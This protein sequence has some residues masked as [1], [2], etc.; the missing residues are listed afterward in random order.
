MVPSSDLIRLLPDLGLPPVSIQSLDLNM[1]D[2]GMTI[3]TTVLFE[4]PLK[5]GVKNMKNVE[6]RVGLEDATMA[7][8]RIKELKLELGFQKLDLEV[9][10]LLEHQEID[11]VSFHDALMQSSEKVLSAK[12]ELIRAAV[13]G[14]LHME[15]LAL[16]DMTKSLSIWLPVLEIVKQIE[17]TNITELVSTES[18]KNTIAGSKLEVSVGSEN[19]HVDSK[20][21]IPLIIPLPKIDF[22]Y[23]TYFEIGQSSISS[24]NINVSPLL[25]LRK[26][27]SVSVDTDILINPINSNAA[28]DTLGYAI[29]PLISSSPSVYIYILQDRILLLKYTISDFWTGMGINFV[30]V[31]GFSSIFP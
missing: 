13:K 3:L 12:Y 15:G 16:E 30:G 27:A 29:N 6:V 17:A 9:E 10:I 18:I 22:P 11:P 31:R 14:P 20:M 28:A 19:I 5:L 8:I 26:E 7:I 25:I 1:S 21:Q 23:T 4:N 2:T 24:M